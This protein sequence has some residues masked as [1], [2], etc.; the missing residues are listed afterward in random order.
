MTMQA[1]PAGV[2]ELTPVCADCNGS[3]IILT[4]RDDGKPDDRKP[5]PS[6]SEEAPP[7]AAIQAALLLKESI[8][9]Q[10]AFPNSV[11]AL[12]T[13]AERVLRAAEGNTD[14]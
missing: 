12:I 9:T 14:A 7:V 13:A 11:T 6:C 8:L 4:K 2:Y 10:T 5:C 1:P 3:E